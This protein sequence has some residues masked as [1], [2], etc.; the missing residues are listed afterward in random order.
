MTSNASAAASGAPTR[1][2]RT[3]TIQAEP[4]AILS[5]WGDIEIQPQLFEG[6]ATYLGPD[7]RGGST[8]EVHA[9]LGRRPRFVLLPDG[10]TAGYVR[11]RVED[12]VGLWMRSEL[13]VRPARARPGVE[14][15]LTVDYRVDGLLAGW[16]ARL[17][18]P[19][20]ALLVGQALRRLR[21]RVEAG[22]IPT[23]ARNPSARAST[24]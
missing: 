8:W 17:V 13:R 23:L 10:E 5:A 1:I 20:P 6:A 18:D 16:L 7:A 19:A 15:T 2:E 3:L 12:E 9:P 24:H 21:A 11:H 4:A 22:E 14:A